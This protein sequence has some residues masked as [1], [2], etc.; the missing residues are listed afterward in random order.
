MASAIKAVRSEEMGLKK[1]Q[2]V[3]EVPRSTPK[4]KDNSKKTDVEKPINNRCG[5]K[6]MLPCSL[7]EEL[8]SYCIMMKR[9]FFGL[10]TRSIKR[11]AFELA[12]K[13][14]L[15]LHWQYNKEEQPGSVCITL[16]AAILDRGCASPKLLRQQE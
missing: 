8:V 9:K 4:N 15:A 12:I 5:R 14:G 6:P 11:T 2:R 10:I 1:T 7:E 13:N 16:S 3:F